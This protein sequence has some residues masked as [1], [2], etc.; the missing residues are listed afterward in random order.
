MYITVQQ[1]VMYIQHDTQKLQDLSEK[2]ISTTI[3]IILSPHQSVV[4]IREVHYFVLPRHRVSL[5]LCILNSTGCDVYSIQNVVMY[6]QFNRWWIY[7]QCNSIVMYIQHDTHKLQDLLE[8]LPSRST[9]IVQSDRTWANFDVVRVQHGWNRPCVK[10][11][12]VCKLCYKWP[13]TSQGHN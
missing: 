9:K 11:S 6:T 8:K 10:T 4:H 5:N 1:V 7:I 3:T 2:K 12:N 13:T